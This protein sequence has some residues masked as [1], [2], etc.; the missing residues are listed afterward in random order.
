[1]KNENDQW[2]RSPPDHARPL[3]RRQQSRRTIAGI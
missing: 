3:P 1:M 2:N